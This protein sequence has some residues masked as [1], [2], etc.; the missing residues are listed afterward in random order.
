ME[1]EGLG[2]GYHGMNPA[3]FT[4]GRVGYKPFRSV[5]QGMYE[6]R[7]INYQ[8]GFK[9]HTGTGAKAQASRFRA[10]DRLLEMAAGYGITPA[11]WQRHFGFMSRPTSIRH[12]VTLKTA[13][14]FGRDPQL[15]LVDF[16]D[17]IVARIASRVN[18]LNAFFAKQVIEP[19]CHYAFVRM[20]S[21]GDRSDFFL[22]SRRA[23]VLRWFQKLS[24]AAK[25][26]DEGSAY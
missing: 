5:V 23:A 16:R 21:K 18:E 19:N 24:A 7:Y 20:F 13:R 25:Q 22:G 2:Y 4:G 8:R 15:M 6:F 1:D 10:T 14:T 12:P 26:V 9:E 3:A 17:A 11:H